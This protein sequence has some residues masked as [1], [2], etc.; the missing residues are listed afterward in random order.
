[1]YID[2]KNK[3]LRWIYPPRCPVCG[4]VLRTQRN[5]ISIQEDCREARVCTECEGKLHKTVPP[6]CYRCGR[7]VGHGEEFCFNCQ[8]KKF[9][10]V[11]GF[12]VWIYDQTMKASI[13]AF[14]Y[15]GRKEYA[16]YYGQEFVKRYGKKLK[17]LS[18]QALIPVPLYPGKQKTRGY[19]Q[20]E[21]FAEEIGR[22]MGIFICRDYLLRICDTVPQK[23]LDDKQRYANL[24]TAFMIDERKRERYTGLKNVLLVDDIYTTG[25]TI[26]ACTEVLLQAGIQNVYFASVSIGSH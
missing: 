3:F 6:V 23:E 9:L 7:P 26:E 17:K 12:P 18:I 19:N 5:G 13:A 2:W 8:K 20:A 14:K 4:D 22:R 15:H 16:A 1:L 25:S 11:R 21:L 10:Y 24:K